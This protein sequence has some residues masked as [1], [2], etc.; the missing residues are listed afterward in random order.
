MQATKE[1]IGEA[2]LNHALKELING[3]TEEQ[4]AR[5]IDLVSLLMKGIER[6][7]QALISDWFTKIITYDLAIEDVI[8]V[9]IRDGRYS[10]SIAVD[11]K[12]FESSPDGL[13]NEVIMDEEITIGLYDAYPDDPK[14]N[15][16]FEK[17]RL[18]QGA[19]SIVVETDK[20]PK[21]VVLDPKMT[22]PDEDVVDNLFEMEN[23]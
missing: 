17:I 11:A 15:V 8:D 13:E 21:Y 5:S 9:K 2:S 18:K 4:S 16:R 14:A 1:L 3:H 7:Q 10:L 20:L 23:E 6:D 12:R 19:N 22:R